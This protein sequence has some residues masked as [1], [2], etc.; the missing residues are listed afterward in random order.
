MDKSFNELFGW[1]VWSV[2]LLVSWLVDYWVVRLGWCVFQLICGRRRVNVI[3]LSNIF[4]AV[5]FSKLNKSTEQIDQTMTSS[6]RPPP[7]SLLYCYICLLLLYFSVKCQQEYFNLYSDDSTEKQFAIHIFCTLVSLLFSHLAFSAALC[8]C[9]VQFSRKYLSSASATTSDYR[10]QHNNLFWYVFLCNFSLDKFVV[11]AT[12]SS[13]R[14][15]HFFL[16]GI[17][18]IN[19]QQCH[20]RFSFSPF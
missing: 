13:L 12:E 1:S 3:L 7:L 10:F 5:S 20:K 11:T 6:H 9:S 14:I 17:C 4:Y 15:L 8:F 2:S 19:C 18:I 16:W